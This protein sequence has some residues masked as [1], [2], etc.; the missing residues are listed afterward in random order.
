MRAGR[1]EVLAGAALA[2]ALVGL[3]ACRTLPPAGEPA[4]PSVR[5][6]LTYDDGP[7]AREG[8]NPTAEILD[9]LADNEVQPD[10]S[11]LFF[12]QSIDPRAGGS[13]RGRA[14]M[15]RMVAEGHVIGLHCVAPG[16]HVAHP[17]LSE[18]QL[19]RLL[20]ESRDLL[21]AKTGAP[22]LFV[23]PPYGAQRE[24][25]RRVYEEKGLHMVMCDARARDGVIY[26]FHDVP[27][28]RARF[29]RA[30]ARLRER[31]PAETGDG[32]PFP[33]LVTFHDLNPSTARRKVEYLHI[34]V[35][36]AE[37][38]GLQLADPPFFVTPAEVTE[39][40]LRRRVPPPEPAP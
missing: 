6:L 12:V 5:F 32:S 24:W 8:F 36:A 34:L 15:R 4:G 17:T 16:G 33:V 1:R 20:R 18:A 30:M 22:P 23:R 39:A 11:A 37:H 2:L 21:H 14:L 26:V 29:R 27:R 7:S 9:R 10:I 13:E 31:L 19:R 3:P 35:E 28:R 38:A 40:A 25:T